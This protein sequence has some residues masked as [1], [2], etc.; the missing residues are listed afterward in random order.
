MAADLSPALV[1]LHQ[2][3]V[4]EPLA[5]VPDFRVGVSPV[6]LREALGF[7]VPEDVQRWDREQR[8]AARLAR[9]E[10]AGKATPA[11]S[12]AESWRLLEGLTRIETLSFAIAS[13][14]AD[15]GELQ[16]LVRLHPRE[17]ELTQARLD[18]G[19]ALAEAHIASAQLRSGRFRYVLDPFSGKQEAKSWNLPRQAGTTLVMCERGENEGRVRKVAQRSLGYMAKHARPVRDL[20]PLIRLTHSPVANLGA[21]ALPAIAFLTCREH[22]GDVHDELIAGMTRFLLTMQRD[23]GSFYPSYEIADDVVIDGPE[24]MY[25]GGQAIFALSLAEK[26]ALEEPERAAALG[27]PSADELHA[28][29][30]RSIGFYTGPYWDN[31]ARDF[32]WLEENWHCLAARASLGHHRSDAYE[33]Y[34]LDYMSYKERLVLDESSR[35]DPEFHGSYALGNILTPVNTPAAGFGE[36]WAAA[37]SIRHARGEDLTQARAKMREVIG[38]LLRQQ[39]TEANCFACAPHRT[40]LGGYSESMSAA[41]IRIDF[42]QHAWAALGH[43]G[44]WIY[45]ELPAE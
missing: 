32:F 1:A 12:D 5:W 19:R 11:P 14:G 44:D 24:P 35:V 30:E 4:N 26:L 43:G 41:E 7:G 22:V 6:A 13:E 28:A 36:G 2:F 23:D 34:C 8:N 16:A 29:V 42:T 25:A 10:E 45:D 38:F 27:M 18:H 21:T 31:F 40:V 33:Q 15:A 17:L 37:M 9:L 3:V 39:W 20:T